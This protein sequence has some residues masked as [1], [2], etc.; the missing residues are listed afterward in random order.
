MNIEHI[1]QVARFAREKAVEQGADGF[2]LIASS[3]DLL[4]VFG[5]M[6]QY[7]MGVAITKLMETLPVH[8]QAAIV[9]KATLKLKQSHA[10]RETQ[11]QPTKNQSK[12]LWAMLDEVRAG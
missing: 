7:D 11:E 4:V 3:E 1:E 9:L 10:E 8:I 2:M 12:A 6:A 5:K